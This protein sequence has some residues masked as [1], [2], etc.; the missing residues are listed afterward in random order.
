MQKVRNCF[1]QYV[2]PRIF[3]FFTNDYTRLKIA[4]MLNSLW[5]LSLQP[6]SRDMTFVIAPP[7]G[8]VGIVAHWLMD[9]GFE[10]VSH[11]ELSNIELLMLGYGYV[12]DVQ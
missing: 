10:W 9:H 8:K 11:Y 1:A 3:V 12:V 4:E 7:D 2:T 6:T 5:G